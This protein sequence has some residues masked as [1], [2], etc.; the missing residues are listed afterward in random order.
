MAHRYSIKKTGVQNSPKC[1]FDSRNNFNRN[2]VSERPIKQIRVPLD[3]VKMVRK[4]NEGW[5]FAQNRNTRHLRKENVSVV[6][7]VCITIMHLQI[8]WNYD[9]FKL[10]LF[11][12]RSIRKEMCYKD[13]Q[14]ISIH[15]CIMLINV[16][17]HI[18]VPWNMYSIKR[19]C[20]EHI[21]PKMIIMVPGHWPHNF[22][23]ICRGYI[24]FVIDF[25]F[26]CYCITTFTKTCQSVE[27]TV[28]QIANLNNI[29]L[30][31]SR[32]LPQT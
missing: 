3:F 28:N 31:S 22:C 20:L 29:N 24:H 13:A 8:W 18:R 11:K 9:F 21:T 2:C 1:L 23:L 30:K 16:F 27:Y 17:E 6:I 26:H 4:D 14:K 25:G 15:V 32:V 7:F 19:R 10:Q 12:N 5:W